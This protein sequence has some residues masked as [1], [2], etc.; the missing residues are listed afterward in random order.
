[1]TRDIKQKSRYEKQNISSETIR[2]KIEI[3]FELSKY[4]IKYTVNIMND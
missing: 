3:A 4:N 2:D 1:M